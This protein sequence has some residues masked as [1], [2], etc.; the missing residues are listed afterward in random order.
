M[1]VLN[2]ILAVLREGVER[3]LATVNSWGHCFHQSKGNNNY[4]CGIGASNYQVALD[5][6]RT[7]CLTK[8]DMITKESQ[9]LSVL[10]YLLKLKDCLSQRFQIF[11]LF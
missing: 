8:L 3:K 6:H 4:L 10:T 11:S 1:V 5:A 9:Q 7:W 2:Y